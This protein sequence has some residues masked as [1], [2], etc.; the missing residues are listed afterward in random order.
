MSAPSGSGRRPSPA[1]ADDGDELHFC[2]TCAFSA[3]CLE[4]GFDKSRLRDF[5]TPSADAR[6]DRVFIAIL[7]GRSVESLQDYYHAQFGVPRA[8]I[9]DA[10]ISVMSNAYGLPARQ[11]HQLSALPLA[12]ACYIEA[13]TMPAQV[14][15]RPVQA[16]EL[17]PAISMVTF[18]TGKLPPLDY[19]GPIV[20]VSEEPYNGRRSAVCRGSAGEL[21]ELIE[22]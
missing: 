11:K 4:Q 7:G 19:L 17:P 14:Q 9:I 1:A 20:T 10:V 22:T 13:D 3:V 15:E 2:S 18:R 6:V 12:D 8:P 5:A 16:G 21:I